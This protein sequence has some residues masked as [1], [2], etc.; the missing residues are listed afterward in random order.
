MRSILSIAI[1]LLLAGLLSCRIEGRSAEKANL[2]HHSNWVRTV[3]GW[4][5]PKN[6]SPS[7]AEPPALHPLVVAAGQTLFSLFALVAAAK[8]PDR[9]GSGR[10]RP[11]E[12]QI[13]SRSEILSTSHQNE[14]R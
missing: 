4:E 12:F 9:G 8:W 1:L 7:L 2:T 5:R 10:H 14:S 11:L 3:D 13:S 6:W